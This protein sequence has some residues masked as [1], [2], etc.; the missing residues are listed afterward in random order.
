MEAAQL[1]SYEAEQSLCDALRECVN[2]Y[3]KDEGRART[4]MTKCW[5]SM[6]RRDTKSLNLEKDLEDIQSTARRVGR[7]EE[8]QTAKLWK[9][10][11]GDE[12]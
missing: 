10:L 3:D 1:K 2:S 8:E 9:Q 11:E 12:Q 4:L 7:F 5:Q 6:L